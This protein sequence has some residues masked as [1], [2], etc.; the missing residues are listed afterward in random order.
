MAIYNTASCQVD[1]HT[2][3]TIANSFSE[4]TTPLTLAYTKLGS[5]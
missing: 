2:S 4:Y 3:K 5:H 1:C